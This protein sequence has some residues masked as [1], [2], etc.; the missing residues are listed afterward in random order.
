MSKKSKKILEEQKPH[1]KKMFEGKPLPN[2]S[3]VEPILE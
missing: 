2:K 1:I 3:G